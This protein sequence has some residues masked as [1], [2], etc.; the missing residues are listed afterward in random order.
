MSLNEYI[1]QLDGEVLFQLHNFLGKLCWN[2]GKTSGV[3]LNFG[4]KTLAL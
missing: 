1:L 4:I 3:G 2:H